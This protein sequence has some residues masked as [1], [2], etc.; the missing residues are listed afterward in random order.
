MNGSTDP[1]GVA[2]DGAG[3]AY[4]TGRT[5][6]GNVPVSPGAKAL[7][8]QRARRR[9][10]HE[11]RCR[12]RTCDVRHV[13]RWPTAD[14]ATSVA[15]DGGG[16]AF[17]TGWTQSPLGDRDAFVW[18][19]D[20]NPEVVAIHV[21]HSPRHLLRRHGRRRR[22]GPA[23]N[24]VVAVESRSGAFP[25]TAPG[26][27]SGSALVRLSADGHLTSS[28]WVAASRLGPTAPT[29]VAVDRNYNAYVVG[30]YG[31]PESIQGIWID[32]I[33]VSGAATATFTLRGQ[34]SNVGNSLDVPAGIALGPAVGDVF[35]TGSTTSFD[36]PTTP[37]A[38]QPLYGSGASDAFVSKVSFQ[39]GSTPRPNLALNKRV[40]VLVVIWPWIRGSQRRRRRPVGTQM[41]EPVQRSSVDLRR[42]RADHRRRRSDPPVGGGVA[43]PITRADVDD[44]DTWRTIRCVTGGDGEVDD[45]AGLYGS[46]RFLRILGTR[47]GTDVGIFAFES[48]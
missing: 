44:A 7:E 25:T 22:G 6:A 35:V 2:V 29:G 46:G 32:R 14:A 28:T 3:N 21:R 17:V 41:V 34:H 39:D 18:K 31:V 1:A 10:P 37:G 24:A 43:A 15:V 12:R 36:F 20:S 48:R 8:R 47:R 33:N 9:L 42:S 16:H 38:P 40:V 19:L 11:V 5:F 27:I 4:V 30:R 45:L 26:T 13:H 23:G